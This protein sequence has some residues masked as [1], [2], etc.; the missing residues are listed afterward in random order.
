M[1]PIGTGLI[2]A[3]ATSEAWLGTRAATVGR[4]AFSGFSPIRVGPAVFSTFE[5]GVLVGASGALNVAITGVSF[6]VGALAGSMISA[7]PT[8]SGDT[9]RDSLADVLF[10]SFGPDALPDE[11]ACGW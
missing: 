7:I 2:T 3:G 11:L 1:A 6:E 10:D 5:S 4:W 8:G 9:I